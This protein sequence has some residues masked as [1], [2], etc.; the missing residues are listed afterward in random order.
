MKCDLKI[1]HLTG[2]LKA[3]NDLDVSGSLLTIKLLRDGEFILE[4]LVASRIVLLLL[5]LLSER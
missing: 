5:F 1:K 2:T 3:E 4:V